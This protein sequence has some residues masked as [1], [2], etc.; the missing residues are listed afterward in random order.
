MAKNDLPK[1]SFLVTS[2]TDHQSSDPPPWAFAVLDQAHM[3]RAE[4]PDR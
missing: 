3:G 1:R 2:R 4:I